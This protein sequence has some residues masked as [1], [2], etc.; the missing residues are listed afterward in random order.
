MFGAG[1]VA[2]TDD[3]GVLVTAMHQ[4][5]WR[6]GPTDASPEANSGVLWA[7]PI[8]GFKNESRGSQ[9]KLEK[10]SS[11]QG[12]PAASEGLERTVI[13]DGDDK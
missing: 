12:R 11:E 2:V 8:C 9:R 4:M 1:V 5:S 13:G 6:R 7:V 3:V 10:R